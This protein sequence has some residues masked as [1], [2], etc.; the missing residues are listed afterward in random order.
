[1]TR[2]LVLTLLT[3]DGVLSAL[4]GALLLPLYLGSVAF[5]IS[6]L[7]CG[8]LNAALVWAALQWTTSTRVA[9]APLW[10]F[11]AAVLVL[12][13]GGPGGDAVFRGPGIMDFRSLLFIV[14]GVAPPAMVLWREQN[15]T[16]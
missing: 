10:G 8:L 1:L 2:P 3:V 14:V 9:A 11:L 5:P 7:V 12:T 6:A 16:I 13:F 4:A 15:S